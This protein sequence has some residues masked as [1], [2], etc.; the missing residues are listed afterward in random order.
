MLNRP[1]LTCQTAL[2]VPGTSRC[3]P[4]GSTFNHARTSHRRTAESTGAARKLRGIV[5]KRGSA[6]CVYCGD[7][8]YASYIEI[9]HAVALIDGGTDTPKN[10]VPACKP[11]H[12]D[13]TTDENKARKA[14]RS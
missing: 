9:D 6:S 2:A 1:C 7:T 4:C 12:R 13:K 10:V 8:F 11:C 14:N 3:R 5:N